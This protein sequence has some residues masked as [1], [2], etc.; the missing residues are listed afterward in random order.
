[1]LLILLSMTYFE[2]KGITVKADRFEHLPYQVEVIEIENLLTIDE[3]GEIL[4]KEGGVKIYGNG[5]PGSLV[6]AAVHG[7]TSKH[8]LIM[9]NGHRINDPKTGGFDL[10]SIPLNA[11]NRIEIIKGSSSVFE[12]SNA[13]GG[14]IN[15]I[16]GEKSNHVRLK[17]NSNNTLG[18]NLQLY[19]YGING[20]L[21]IEKG[22]GQR[23]NTDFQHYSLSLNWKDFSFTAGHKDLG[24]PGVLPDSDIIPMFGDSTA[25]SLFDNQK[26]QFADLS[27][28]KIFTS[29]DIGI[30]I[31]PVMT[32]ELFKY[33]WQYSDYMTGDTVIEN[34]TYKTIVSQFNTKLLYKMLSVSINLEKDII[35]MEWNPSNTEAT[36]TSNEEEK[37]GIT[38]SLFHETENIN[39]FVSVR[40]DWY[41]SF[42]FHPSFTI[43]SRINEPIEIFVSVGSAFQA[44]TLNDLYYPNY[45]NENLQPEHSFGLTG[46][47]KI[48]R[49]TI[50]GHIEQIRDR[51]GLDEYWI[52]QNIS[53]TRVFGIDIEAEGKYENFSYSLIYSYLDG[54]DEEN[55]L[56]RELQHQPKHSIAGIITY[57]GPVMAEVSAKW[58]GEKKKWFSFEGWKK[59]DQALI[60][61]VGIS[62]K[63]NDFSLGLSIENLLNIEYITSFGYSYTDRDYPGMGRYSNIWTEYSF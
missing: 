11:V 59:E 50:S 2:S 55:E 17:G 18:A 27:Y 1:M 13:I 38:L 53:K 30:L 34:D 16:T 32:G 35:W 10:S 6:Q 20:N 8:T 42:G 37:A 25:T 31:E 33:N 47:I 39:T 56:K 60:I 24:V 23:S 44:P 5:D 62:K 57:E 26:T 9:L 28:S 45:S 41:G 43:G 36:V 22:K 63:F 61:D 40:E 49:L 48:K 3:L 14:V 58:A 15:I 19:K 12:G 21:N 54:Y 52:P 29:G 4:E 46:G 7:Y 51:I